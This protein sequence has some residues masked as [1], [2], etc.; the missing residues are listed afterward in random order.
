[1]IAV[2]GPVWNERINELQSTQ[3]WVRRELEVGLKRQI[4]MVPLLVDGAQIPS[5][6]DLPASLMKLF[7]YEVVY[8]Y[9]RH[10]KENVSELVDELSKGLNLPKRQQ[11][12][13]AIPNLSGDWSD[14]DGIHL[15][16]EHRGE[17][18]RVF[19]STLA[20]MPLG[21]VMAPSPAIRSSF[22]YGV[23]T[24]GSVTGPEPSAPM[25][26]RSVEPSSMVCNA[27]ASVF[28]GTEHALR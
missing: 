14:T 2:I 28:R 21:R 24:T 25:V 8:V 18:L 27:S 23:P 22:R 11:R 12:L 7:D 3:D 19:C 6:S 16:L 10:W 4:L 15:K 26:A 1:M 5:M 20:V 17:N 9:P 13:A